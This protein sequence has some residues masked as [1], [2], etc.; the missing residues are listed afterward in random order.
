MRTSEPNVL[1]MAPH[2]PRKQSMLYSYITLLNMSMVKWVRVH[3]LY[4]IL[5]FF[6]DIFRRNKLNEPVHEN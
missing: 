3:F 6:E 5:V 1:P 4:G 2:P